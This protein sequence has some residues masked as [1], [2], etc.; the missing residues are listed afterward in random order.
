ML[1]FILDSRISKLIAK[2]LAAVLLFDNVLFPAKIVALTGGPMQAEYSGFSSGSSDMV[3]LFTGDFNYNIHL[4]DVD[5]YPINLGYNANPGIDQEA[6]WVGLGWTLNSGAITRNVRGVPDDF[7]KD[8]I[9]REVTMKDHKAWGVVPGGGIE[10]AGEGNFSGGVSGGAGVVYSN[11]KGLGYEFFL[12]PSLSI[13]MGDND[14]LKGKFSAGLGLRVNSQEGSSFNA[15]GGLS[16][17]FQRNNESHFSTGVGMNIGS[18]S[19]SRSG[20]DAWSLGGSAFVSGSQKTEMNKKDATKIDPN[21]GGV[22]VSFG[23]SIP[24]NS[25]AYTPKLDFDRKSSLLS[26][27]FKIGGANCAVFGFASVRGFISQSSIEHNSITYESYGY[28]YEHESKNNPDQYKN[29]LLDYARDK[30]GTFYAETPNAPVANHTYDMFVASAHGLYGAFHASRNDVGIVYDPSAEYH[31]SSIGVGAEIGFGAGVNVGVNT[32]YVDASSS[33]GAWKGNDYNSLAGYAGFKNDESLTAS[34]PIDLIDEAYFK[35]A[36][37]K[38][39]DNK[40]FYAQ[41][42]GESAVRP[43]LEAVG[44]KNYKTTDKI[45]A[46]GTT[47]LGP[48]LTSQSPIKTERNKRENLIA[49]LNAS[50]ASSFGI[51]KDIK[52]YPINT[53]G[54]MVYPIVSS[55]STLRTTQANSK[56][57]H[58]SEITVLQTNGSRYV[59]GIPV[60]NRK[61]VDVSF[62]TAVNTPPGNGLINYTSENTL[63]DASNARPS[64]SDQFYE[65]NTVGDYAPSYLLTNI[66]SDDYVDKLYD[67]VTD[68]DLGSFT[69][70]KYS[71]SGTYKWRMPAD[72][73]K[74]AFYSEGMYSDKND[75]RGSYSYGEKEIWYPRSIEGRNFYAE[76]I[77]ED[78]LDGAPVA[79][80]DGT[81]DYSFKL[82]RLKQIKLYAKPKYNGTN[83][84]LVKTV[85]FEYD[86]SLCPNTPNSNGTGKGKLTLKKIW[87]GTGESNKGALNPY[88]FFYCDPTHIGDPVTNNSVAALNGSSNPG[89]NYYYTDRW[90]SYKDPANNLSGLSNIEFPYTIQQG[91]SANLNASVW[92]LNTVFT[93]SGS[94]I[95]IDYEADTYSY[96]NDKPAAQMYKTLG[97]SNSSSSGPG[98]QLFTVSSSK[99]ISSN[100]YL[101]VQINEG[102]SN[103]MTSADMKQYFIDHYLGGESKIYFKAY[104]KIDNSNSSSYEYIPGYADVSQSDINFTGLT[105]G[106]YYTAV[107]KL[108]SVDI[109]DKVALAGSFN[110]NPIAKAALQVGRM[111]VPKIMYPGSEPASGGKSALD[112]LLSAMGDIKAMV[113]GVNKALA[114]KKRCSV[115]DPSRS[116]VR[117][118]NPGGSKFGGGSRV[119][120]LKITDNWA[121]MTSSNEAGSEYGQ[122]YQYTTLDQK[123][124]T[125]SSGVANYE[126]LCGGDENSNRKPI[127]FN[128]PASA[129]LNNSFFQEDPY[130]ESFYPNGNVGYSRVVVKNLQ[131]TNVTRHASGYTEHTFYTTRDYPV[132]EERTILEKKRVQPSLAS[133]VFNVNVQDKVYLSQ[134]FVVKTND[135]HGKLKSVKLYGEGQQSPI[136]G[137]TYN[138]KT[139]TNYKELDNVVSVLGPDQLVSSEEIGVETDIVNDSRSSKAEI[140]SYSAMVNV[141]D[142]PCSYWVPLVFFWPGYT[143][144]KTEF[145][146]SVFTK[147]IQ[148]FGILESVEK[149]DE[150]SVVK[151]S[152]LLFDKETGDCILSSTNNQFDKPVYN[153]NYPAYWAYD[154]MGSAHQNIGTEF[155]DI[156]YPYQGSTS[157]TSGRIASS[158]QNYFVPGDEVVIYDAIL[159]NGKYTKHNYVNTCWVIQDKTASGGGNMYLIDKNGFRAS[160]GNIFIT[161]SASYI[162][163]INRSGRRNL[164]TN[165]IGNLTSLTYPIDG[166]NKVLLTSGVLHASAT[167]YDEKWNMNCEQCT[168]QTLAT[169][170]QASGTLPTAIYCNASSFGSDLLNNFKTMFDY[171]FAY[172]STYGTPPSVGIA[173]STKLFD[174]SFPASMQD[175]YVKSWPNTPFVTPYQG[176]FVNFDAFRQYALCSCTCYLTGSNPFNPPSYWFGYT[177]EYYNAKIATVYPFKNNSPADYRTCQ[178]N[179][180]GVAH[181]DYRIKQ[182]SIFSGWSNHSCSSNP[183]TEQITVTLDPATSTSYGWHTVKSVSGLTPSSSSAGSVLTF[184]GTATMTDN[185]TAKF[186]GNATTS[187]CLGSIG[188]CYV[189]TG[190]APIEACVVNPYLSGLRGN[191]RPKRTYDYFTSRTQG[192][193]QAIYGMSGNLVNDGTYSTF[194]PFWWYQGN[195]LMPVTAHASRNSSP[196]SLWIKNSELDKVDWYGNACQ[197]RNALDL[198]SSTIY[199]YGVNLPVAV[200]SNAYNNEIL[201]DGF[202]DNLSS[203]VNCDGKFKFNY[204]SS[205]SPLPVADNTQ[206]HTGFYSLK[207][208]ANNKAVMIDRFR[209]FAAMNANSSTADV[210]QNRPSTSQGIYVVKTT[211]NLD[212]FGPFFSSGND[213]FIVSVWVKLMGTGS[214]SYN[215]YPNVGVNLGVDVSGTGSYIYRSPVS[216]EKTAIVNGWQKL[217]YYFNDFNAGTAGSINSKYRIDLFNSNSIGSAYFD[218]IRIHPYNSNMLSKVYN[219]GTLE[220]MAELDDRNFATVYQYDADHNLVR[221]NK[222]TE[223]GVLTTVETR[224]GLKK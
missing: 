138:Y 111:Q 25:T 42:G 163:K 173:Y 48:S 67:G 36:G 157:S 147:T 139:K 218:D 47:P 151:T 175:F 39:F 94:K 72:G 7:N 66:L 130:C 1:Q 128:L 96:V 32:N 189:S 35:F 219:P 145:Y 113:V 200:A 199:G 114:Q 63:G 144:S 123:G 160:T 205:P 70:F 124:N 103:T 196:Y 132:K 115:F 155:L 170:L 64:N 102:I 87:F 162:F 142:M 143:K 185:T 89:Y 30:D 104:V 187:A 6:S 159:A 92:N 152:N 186:S 97:A 78:R 134:G 16:G 80:E 213:K 76:F 95:S 179:F 3:D 9:K 165:S 91:N 131:R 45:I 15:S 141:S 121:A 176:W 85:N 217:E 44:T 31:G 24:L 127:S 169:N 174:P 109:G 61:Q 52:E 135:M 82:K 133:R 117:L 149:F 181:W 23:G 53:T 50:E 154:G 86:Y 22:G 20:R 105:N 207:V 73:N 26:Y 184:T 37:E 100:D 110:I 220:L 51:D 116:F 120:Q 4:M 156:C 84:T 55:A 197:T 222:E 204:S 98:N 178:L 107:L 194:T 224:K 43:E 58:I 216:V 5:G 118:Y 49:Y 81:V 146:S 191:W 65:K 74:T 34:T 2:V 161:S 180:Q 164:Q 122:T 12:E 212:N 148:K 88:N 68:D 214:A 209:D 206:A 33:S 57:H 183:A 29:A 83:P 101:Y 177:Y 201:S 188:T 8:E 59:Y 75:Q 126:P 21:G 46:S 60:Y 19:N 202:E 137:I 79:G 221:I 125:I 10:I 198:P 28:L 210:Y 99:V 14:G 140:Q 215:S 77:L 93:P 56:S 150:N 192:G 90:G 40:A 18:S 13:A 158:F 190:S 54:N 166:T 69:K 203:V 168:P 211:D 171:G 195:K 193:P 41:F 27:D 167:E 129:S 71:R 38:V 208:A 62:A 172:A 112:G 108:T 106:S 136:S 223:K 153:F 11:Y 119:S 182:S 17:Q